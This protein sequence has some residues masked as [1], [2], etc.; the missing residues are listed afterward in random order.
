MIL[1]GERGGILYSPDLLMTGPGGGGGGGG[2]DV[3]E[4]ERLLLR[5]GRFEL[6]A[7]VEDKVG[8]KLAKVGIC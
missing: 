5:L 8:W 4:A 1:R 6:N 2:G 7:E 3:E